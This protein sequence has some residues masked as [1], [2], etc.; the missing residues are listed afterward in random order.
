MSAPQSLDDLLR[1]ELRDLLDGE[2]QITKAL[3]R[4]AKAAESAPLRAAMEQH[5]RETE[6]Q[7]ERLNQA[8]DLL[9]ETPRRKTCEGIKGLIAEAKEM[10]QELDKGAVLDA[11]LIAAAQKVEHYEI[12]SYGTVRTYASMLGHRDVAALFE[13]TLREEK[14]TDQ[15]LT[16]L[17]EGLVNP[18]AAEEES[19]DESDSEGLPLRVARTM[20]T[21]AGRAAALARQA[22]NSIGGRVLPTRASATS[23]RKSTARK[24]SSRRSSRKK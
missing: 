8:F 23:T 2:T 18:E 7:I 16:G 24:S 6:G 15:K 19:A 11:A 9:D 14:A 4:M 5:L 22:A 3:P 17:A 13:A 20:G 21:A 12:A 10:M 1:E